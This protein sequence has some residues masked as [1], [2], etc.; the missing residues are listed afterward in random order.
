MN[1]ITGLFTVSAILICGCGNGTE[2]V[3]SDGTDS[4]ITTPSAVDLPGSLIAPTGDYVKTSP[5]TDV[6][7][8]YWL[9]LDK[10]DD[11]RTDL[12]FLASL[13]S[14]FLVLPIQPDHESRNHAQ[15]VINNMGVSL[16]VYLADSI[17]MELMGTDIM[18]SCLI[19]TPA[20]EEIAGN[21]FGS[22]ARLLSS[23]LS[24]E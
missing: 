13:D 21:G 5:G 2:D 11:M 4:L 6:I 15:R 8:Y 16:P 17:V 23:I 24:G 1:R 14:T 19:L 12:L 3:V 9:P 22:P 7:L 20:G 18:P 10:H